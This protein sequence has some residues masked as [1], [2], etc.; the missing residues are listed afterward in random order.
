MC[1]LCLGQPREEDEHS[2]IMYYNETGNNLPQ[3]MDLG[4][5]KEH[6]ALAC[7]PSWQGTRTKNLQFLLGQ[8]LK[9]TSGLSP[10]IIGS[11]AQGGTCG[12]PYL[13]AAVAGRHH[14]DFSTLG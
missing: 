3:D 2:H 1:R 14:L 6:R 11:L 13:H 7:F 10:T 12:M 8:N 5:Q 4:S 9:P